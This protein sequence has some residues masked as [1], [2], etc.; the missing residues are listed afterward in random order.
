MIV[1]VGGLTRYSSCQLKGSP[2][3]ISAYNA[4]KPRLKVITNIPDQP[5]KFN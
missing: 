1:E 2:A 5:T 3:L 4:K